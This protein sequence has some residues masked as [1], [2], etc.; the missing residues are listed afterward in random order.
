[1]KFLDLASDTIE[2]RAT[3]RRWF[4]PLHASVDDVASPSDQIRRLHAGEE[5]RFVIDRAAYR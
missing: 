1:M 5:L 4:H 2:Q 3:S